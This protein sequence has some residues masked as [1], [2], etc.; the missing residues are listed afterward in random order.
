MHGRKAIVGPVRFK[1]IF[2]LTLQDLPG[3]MQAVC[4]ESRGPEGSALLHF[5]QLFPPLHH[6]RNSA[7]QAPHLEQR[8]ARHSNRGD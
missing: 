3:K 8:I 2:G 4:P 7:Y 5:I 6:S 1:T